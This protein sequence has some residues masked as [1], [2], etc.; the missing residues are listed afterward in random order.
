[1]VMSHIHDVASFEQKTT[2]LCWFPFLHILYLSHH[3]A[4]CHQVHKF[5]GHFT[6]QSHQ[7][8]QI[9]LSVVCQLLLPYSW[10]FA[11]YFSLIDAHDFWFPVIL[12]EPQP[13]RKRQSF[14]NN[15]LVI[16]TG[17]SQNEGFHRIP[18]QGIDAKVHLKFLHLFCSCVIKN[19]VVCIVTG[20]CPMQ[21]NN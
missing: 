21:E 15:L 17:S 2:H 18:C 16:F 3:L 5:I 9:I 19:Y 6:N 11:S 13:S 14:S 12:G 10:F 20:C 7:S 4:T 1:M 8:C